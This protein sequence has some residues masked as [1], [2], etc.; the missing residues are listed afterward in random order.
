MGERIQGELVPGVERGGKQTRRGTR[1]FCVQGGRAM[2]WVP[3]LWEKVSILY[4]GTGASRPF[5]ASSSL[6][7][8]WAWSTVR[9]GSHTS[10]RRRLRGRGAAPGPSP[11]PCLVEN[12]AP[13]AP[14]R[15]KRGSRAVPVPCP[16]APKAG[17]ASSA[18]PPSPS[19][20]LPDGEVLWPLSACPL[21]GAG[22]RAARRQPC[23]KGSLRGSLQPRSTSPR[24]PGVGRGGSQEVG[25]SRLQA[26]PPATW[27]Q[28]AVWPVL[29]GFSSAALNLY[30]PLFKF[31]LIKYTKYRFFSV[32]E[33]LEKTD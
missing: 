20:L 15:G 6:V 14:S 1:P 32:V 25:G 30:S 23:V 5:S 18:P 29:L 24:G 26:P 27:P 7:W 4:D 21:A 13:P 8:G 10:C 19:P 17:Q 9:R 12:G 16:P 22:G 28:T 2:G 31:G 11:V 3:S 33:K